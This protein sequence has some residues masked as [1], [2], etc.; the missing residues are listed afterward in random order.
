MFR[1]VARYGSVNIF[2]LGSATSMLPKHAACTTRFTTT[3]FVVHPDYD[4]CTVA[5][6]AMQ[7]WVRQL[8]LTADICICRCAVR[9]ET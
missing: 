1:V 6:R 9:V 3:T 2:G 5:K 4:E 7:A 8:T